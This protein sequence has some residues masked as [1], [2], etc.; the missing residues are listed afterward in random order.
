M[1]IITSSELDNT[2]SGENA[3]SPTLIS[4]T[5]KPSSVMSVT[6]PRALPN[7]EYTGRLTGADTNTGASE[8]LPVSLPQF[9]SIIA[10]SA[11]ADTAEGSK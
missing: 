7:G 8:N 6:R 1:T 3:S 9:F 4:V 2:A 5:E 10:S 11:I